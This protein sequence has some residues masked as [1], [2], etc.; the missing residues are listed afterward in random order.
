MEARPRA[1]RACSASSGLASLSQSWGASGP[2]CMPGSARRERLVIPGILPPPLT[3]VSGSAGLKWRRPVLRSQTS[4]CFG[5][6]FWLPWGLV[7]AGHGCPDPHTS[8]TGTTP[9]NPGAP[10]LVGVVSFLPELCSCVVDFPLCLS[11]LPR[12]R[13]SLLLPIATEQQLGRAT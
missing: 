6:R 13:S 8:P 2:G 11:R 12:P 5:N 7:R 10:A 1:S 3:P 4:A 9:D